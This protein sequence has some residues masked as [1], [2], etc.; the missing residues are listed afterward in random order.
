M[1][2]RDFALLFFLGNPQPFS[3]TT[4]Y[5]IGVLDAWAES[6]HPEKVMKCKRLVDIMVYR[7]V[8]RNKARSKPDAFVFTTLIK[9]CV[10]TDDVRSLKVATEAMERL[11]TQFRPANDVAYAMYLRALV[12]FVGTDVQLAQT[13]KNCTQ[14]GFLSNNVVRELAKA[15]NIQKDPLSL[16]KDHEPSWSRNVRERDRPRF[17]SDNNSPR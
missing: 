11:Q 17:V 15:T 8:R 13:I 4:C 1:L 3:R 6:S 9:A 7:Y 5:W 14:G 10:N 12:K 2:V 16:L